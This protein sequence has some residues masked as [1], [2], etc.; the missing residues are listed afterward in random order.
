MRKQTKIAALVSAAALLAIGASMTS[1]AAS[2]WQNENGVWV[3]R[4]RYGDPA[5]GW[6]RYTP[7][8]AMCYADENGEMVFSR[9]VGE[10]GLDDI[11]GDSNIYYVDET[12][13]RVANKWVSVP[14]DG[15]EDVNG[16]YVDTF[17]YYFGSDYR[18][19]R[20][21][22]ASKKFVV[23]T[24][25]ILDNGLTDKGV[26]LFDSL[27][28][29]VTGFADADDTSTGA[30]YYCVKSDDKYEIT[31]GESNATF[32]FYTG[33]ALTGW[34]QMLPPDP[35]LEDM[36]DPE[37]YY[38][39]S[40]GK[41][42]QDEKP[43]LINGKYYAFDNETGIMEDGFYDVTATSGDAAEYTFYTY[44]NVEEGGK[45]GNGWKYDSDSDKWYYIVNV[46]DKQS[47]LTARG[48]MF[49]NVDDDKAAMQAKDIDDHIFLFD[50]KGVMQTGHVVLEANDATNSVWNGIKAY[51][52]QGATTT[53]TKADEYFFYDVA[54][55][56]HRGE[57][58]TGQI[59][60][61]EDGIEH[62]KYFTKTGVKL[63]SVVGAFLY[64]AV[65]GELQCAH[66]G[67]SFAMYD[68]TSTPIKVYKESSRTG[69]TE[70]MSDNKAVTITENH[71]A[72]TVPSGASTKNAE[73]FVIVDKSG[74][75]VKNRNTVKID[76]LE[77][78]VVDYYVYPKTTR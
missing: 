6:H 75:I 12:G 7:T 9:L 30:N 16:E 71:V 56:G 38:Y 78:K 26:Y 43:Y 69:L 24:G 55:T 32:Q 33:R 35:E 25:V 34:V 42:R 19:Y 20:N 65:D 51:D 28:R 29:M 44:M 60:Y 53:Y 8:G 13:G 59:K 48:V 70:L 46:R 3:Y 62:V 11:Y 18:A 10:N 58:R 73:N 37:W 14:N 23:K 68:I 67:E 39:G 61:D 66:D 63:H 74:R 64:G 54:N 76:E 72:D 2:G 52:L 1:L 47:K 50:G 22:D 27:G 17:W 36:D 15:D 45:N 57:L 31:L 77:Y 49:N 4:D 5:E 41:R 21:T 40:D